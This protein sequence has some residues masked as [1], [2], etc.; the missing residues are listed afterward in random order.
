MDYQEELRDLEKAYK[1]GLNMICMDIKRTLPDLLECM[2]KF[3]TLHKRHDEVSEKLDRLL[4]KMRVDEVEDD[5][6]EC[7]TECE[8]ECNE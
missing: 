6:T 3:V 7:D 2:E 1:N 4:V 8:G 5:E